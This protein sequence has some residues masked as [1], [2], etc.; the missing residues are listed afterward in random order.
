M[1]RGLIEKIKNS[2][3]SKTSRNALVLMI[4]TVASQAL[5]LLISPVLTRLFSPNEFGLF[6]L[7]FS[8]SMILWVFI[9]GKYD[10]AIIIPRQDD[11]ANSLTQLAIAIT[12]IISVLLLLPSV[13]FKNEIAVLL[14]NPSLKNYIFLLPVSALF[15]GLYQVFNY[16]CNRNEMYSQL[17]WSRFNR[18]AGTSGWSILLGYIHI[19]GGLIIG[20]LLGQIVSTLVLA[21][22]ALK[23]DI[24]L[25][26][27]INI[28]QIKQVALK[29]NDFPKYNIPSSLLE[30]VSGQLPTLLFTSFYGLSVVGLFGFSQRIISAPGTVISKATGDVFRQEASKRF[31]EHGECGSLFDQAFKKLLLLGIIPFLI[32]GLFSPIIFSLVFGKQWQEAGVYAQ[33]LTPMFYLQ[34]VVSPLSTMF[35]IAQKQKT[36]LLMQMGLALGLLISLLIGKFAFN[37]EKITLILVSITYSIKYLIEFKLSKKYS[38][39]I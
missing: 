36:D 30:K 8:V 37:S 27:V 25:F 17:A 38:R 14:D 6:S 10:M 11:E 39:G 23:K 15:L 12:I 16:W 26:T 28:K 33:L 9:T 3:N 18:S 24:K 34:F 7:Y 13:L 19:T 31:A 22:R 35:L 32:I 1:L 2:L 20:D 5:P 21:Y 4:G 29:Y